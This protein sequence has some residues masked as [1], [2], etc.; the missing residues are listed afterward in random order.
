MKLPCLF[1]PRIL[2]K[3]V[4]ALTHKPYT[5]PFPAGPA[6][7]PIEQFRGR[8]RFNQDKCIGCGA[9][10]NV[11]PAKCI[12]VVDDIAG[13]TPVRKLVHHV[14]ACIWCGQCERYCPTEEGIRQSLEYDCAAFSLDDLEET[15]E[16][17]LLCC[18]SCGEI[19]APVDQLRWLARR[20]GPMAFSNPTLMLVSQ[21]EL[22]VVDEGVGPA[23]EAEYV[24]RG[25]RVSIQCSHC[26]RKTAL[27][28]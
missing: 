26:R 23:A 20:L 10:A 14:D 7:E 3:A 2:K 4:E 5:A 1:Q 13:E 24:G 6:Y 25:R 18:E 11:C 21:M 19:I 8:P 17:E 28:V 9:C 16:K 27:V 15:C 22:T 12:D